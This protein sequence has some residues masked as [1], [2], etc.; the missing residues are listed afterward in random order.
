MT[1]SHE[2]LTYS[3][4]LLTYSHDLLTLSHEL[5]TLSHELLTLSHDLLT[6][7]HDLL[8]LS[9]NRRAA[10]EQGAD[11]RAAIARAWP[12]RDP[13]VTRTKE[14]PHF[15]L[16][17]AHSPWRSEGDAQVGDVFAELEAVI[18]HEEHENER[19]RLPVARHMLVPE[20]SG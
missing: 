15:R 3:H 1:Y 20:L 19:V 2:L 13:R 16:L 4:D 11:Y 10:A 8:T 9:H 17:Q 7:S 6:L 14:L 12:A 5:L 18:E